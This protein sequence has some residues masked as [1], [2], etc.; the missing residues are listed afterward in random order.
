M[1]G[2]NDLCNAG[3]WDASPS[4]FEYDMSEWEDGGD[5]MSMASLEKLM[6]A[7]EML[8]SDPEEAL[9]MMMEEMGCMSNEDCEGDHMA[10]D[11]LADFVDTS[12]P[13]SFSCGWIDMEQMGD[14]MSTEDF[15][16]PTALCGQEFEQES[17]GMEQSTKIY[18][19]DGRMGSAL[20]NALSALS[21]AAAVYASM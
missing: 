10:K 1:A 13:D 12:M 14:Q 11:M 7:M 21:L 5:D 4:D 3:Y 16:M 15:C 6:G 19:Y 8:F 2:M 20:R 17:M 9:E 18:C